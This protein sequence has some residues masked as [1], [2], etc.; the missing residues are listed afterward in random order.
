M[1][2][3]I[4]I[5]LMLGLAGCVADAKRRMSAETLAPLVKAYAFRE[6]PKLN[7]STQFKIEEYRVE[8]LQAALRIQLFLVRYM[9]ADGQQ[10]NESLLIYRDG[11][12][13]PFASAFGGHGLMSAV[14][15]EDTLYYTYSFGSGIHRSHVGVLSIDDG[16]MQILES[17]GH[18]STDLFVRK[19]EGGIQV[20][21]GQFHRFNSWNPTKVVGRVKRK[22]SSLAVVDPA[23]IEVPSF[24]TTRKGIQQPTEPDKK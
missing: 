11:K 21:A 20:E 4:I 23:G 10:F 3:M 24:L 5:L 1:N 12:L 17:G 19:I 15:V 8:G 18:I 22:P 6:I 16:K 7:P 2:R 14:M 13:T 9:S